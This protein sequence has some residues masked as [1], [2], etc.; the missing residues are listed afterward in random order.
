MSSIVKVY[1]IVKTLGTLDRFLQISRGVFKQSCDTTF[2]PF[3]LSDGDA[4]TIK[5][6]VFYSQSIFSNGELRM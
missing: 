4:Y 2:S 3:S 1:K 5:V 6:N